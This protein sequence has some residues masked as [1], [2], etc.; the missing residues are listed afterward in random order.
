MR[1]WGKDAFDE[2]VGSVLFFVLT[3]AAFVALACYGQLT[4]GQRLDQRGKSDYLLM[5]LQCALALG[6]MSLPVLADRKWH[7]Q[8]PP[9]M[10]GMIYG[11][12]F[13]A[14]FL[15][16]VMLFYD[17][18]PL[19]DVLL[20][21]FS[22]VILCAVGFILADR[23]QIEHGAAPALSAAFAFA[24]AMALGGI[25]EIYEYGMDGL[26]HLNMQKFADAQRA[27]F[28]GRAALEDTMVDLIADAL[29]AAA[30]AILGYCIRKRN[31]A[32]D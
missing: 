27:P 8:L 29:A 25:W 7:L 30:A 11:F 32:H 10:L 3:G 1:R 21:G 13:C 14:V 9:K 16:E 18:V 22:G 15:G 2:T 26:L 6:G 4:E 12:L 23:M 5:T 24:F 31:K 20:H 19:W 17:R 28:S